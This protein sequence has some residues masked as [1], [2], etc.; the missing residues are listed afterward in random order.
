VEAAEA[1]A[2]GLVNALSEPDALLDDALALAAFKDKR[3][4]VFTGR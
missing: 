4:P 2:L 3:P 1:F